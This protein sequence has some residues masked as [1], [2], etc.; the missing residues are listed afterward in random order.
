MKQHLEARFTNE[1][2]KLM[3]NHN[4]QEIYKC[5]NLNSEIYLLYHQ[6]PSLVQKR[7]QNILI[8]LYQSIFSRLDQ[9]FQSCSD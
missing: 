5:C 8:M 9:P 7:S 1:D 4:N 3:S 2:V 6:I